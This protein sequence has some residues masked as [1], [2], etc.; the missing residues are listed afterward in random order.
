ML[1]CCAVGPMLSN[2]N[3]GN[4]LLVPNLDLEEKDVK[5]MYEEEEERKKRRV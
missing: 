5:Q 3:I 1:K 2:H 4:I